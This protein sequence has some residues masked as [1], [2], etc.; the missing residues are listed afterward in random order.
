M[1]KSMG[2]SEETTNQV[3]ANQ[4]M[5]MIR[6]NMTPEIILGTNAELG[7][8]MRGEIL[9]LGLKS[10]F[11]QSDCTRPHNRMAGPRKQFA[12]KLST[13]EA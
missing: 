13:T 11:R 8:M 3:W 7:E 1:F 4:Y 5:H 10:R 2:A 12:G 6:Q 9:V